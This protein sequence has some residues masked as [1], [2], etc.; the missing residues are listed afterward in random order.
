MEQTTINSTAQDAEAARLVQGGDSPVRAAVA[1]AFRQA[2]AN[3]E[4]QLQSLTDDLILLASGMDSLC[5]A[6]VVAQLEDELN[7]DPF[8][9]AEEVFFPVT[10]GEFVA[11]YEGAAQ[12]AA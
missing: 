5:F 10:F 11:L 7:L 2:A 1:E 4:R 9:D 8:S 6:I 3:Q 12:K